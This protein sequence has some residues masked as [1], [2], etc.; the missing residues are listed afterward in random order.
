VTVAER[1]RGLRT[2]VYV[3]GDS[4]TVGCAPAIRRTLRRH[5]RDVALDAAVGRFTDPG[6]SALARDPRARRA[7]VWVVALGTNDGPDPRRI[8]NHVNRSL[9]LAGPRREV[10]WLTVRRPGGYGRVNRVL[11]S[12][13]RRSDRL[14][15]I[16][17]AGITARHP[18]L[19]ASD[20]VHATPRGYRIR[21][22]LIART[23]LFL[24]RHP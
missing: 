12:M 20:G 3:E 10:I 9:R 15:L 8:R 19:L 4:L 5:V 23:A 21:G 2:R 1:E 16:D 11:R 22:A 24:A 18:G 13:D 7:R 6:L 14:H 17:W